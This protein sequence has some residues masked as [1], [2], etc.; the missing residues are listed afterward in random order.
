[1]HAIY[2][3]DWQEAENAFQR[4]M[5]LNPGYATAPHWY[6]MQLLT[7]LGR[8]DEALA[9]LRHASQLDPITPAIAASPG[10]VPYAARRFEESVR[11]QEK[12][13]KTEPAFFPLYHFM[14]Q[15]L[16]QLGE[17]LMAI[18]SFE[19]ALEMSDRASEVLASLAHACAVSGDTERAEKLLAELNRTAANRYV[20]PCLFAQVHVGLGQRAE[21][22]EFLERGLQIRAAEMSWLGVRP[23]FD[24]LRS[25]PRFRKILET[26]NLS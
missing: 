24:G 10:P 18:N 14:G 2:D 4:S 16:L 1:M 9:Q 20:S 13:L 26:M 11:W 8:F 25:E 17:K 3:W 21:A 5:S 7:P 12:V 19:R 22:L 6:A 15:S 23:V